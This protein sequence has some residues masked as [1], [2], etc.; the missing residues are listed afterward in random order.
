MWPGLA[1]RPVRGAPIRLACARWARSDELDDEI[2]TRFS[3][4]L[5]RSWTSPREL[6]RALAK[7][8]QSM[9]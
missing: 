4:G 8:G 5:S 9:D 3:A 7:Q 2:A 1:V 6:R